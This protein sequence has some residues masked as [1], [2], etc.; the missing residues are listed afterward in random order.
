MHKLGS[1]VSRRLPALLLVA[2]VPVEPAASRERRGLQLSDL[3]ELR[4]VSD[5]RL[6]PDGKKILY[7]VESREGDRHTTS[8]IFVWDI[9]SASSAPLLGETARGVGPRW[10]PDGK[11]IAYFGA[12]GG[13]FGLMVVPASG[14]SGKLLAKVQGTNH[15]LPSSGESL[16]WSPD[17]RGIAFVSAVA[18][19]ETQ[20]AGGDPAVITRYLYKPHAGEGSTRFNDNRRL[21]IFTVSIDGS[22]LR[23]LTHGSRYEHSIDWSPS[24][25]EILF[26]SNWEPDPDRFFN[27]DIFAVKVSDGSVR[28]LTRTENIEYQPQWSPDGSSIAYLGTKRGLTSS[29]TTM[30]DTHL[31]IMDAEGN[32]RRELGATVDNRQRDHAWSPD[33]K[34]IWCTVQERGRI[35]LYRFPLSGE[36][37]SAVMPRLGGR[38][39]SWSLGKGGVIA[40]STAT[41]RDLPQLYLKSGPAEPRLLTDLNRE[42]LSSREI[43]EVESV[44]FLSFDGTEVEAFLTH[45]LGRSAGSKHP[46]IAVIKGGPHGQDGPELDYR[47]QVYAARGWASLKVNYRG[48]TG[49]GQAFAD[50]IFGDQN[51]GE[52][53]DVLYGVDAVVRRT[54][55]IDADRLGLQGGSYGGQLTMW[56]VTQTNRFRAA[57]PMYGISNLISFN[58]MAYYHDYLAVEFGT[59]PHQGDLMD[60]LWE[61][62]ALKHVAK[63]KT[64][65]LLVHGENDNDVPIAESEQFYVALK[66]VGVE[67]MMVRYPREG[68]GI[69]EIGHQIDLMERSIAWY[70]KHFLPSSGASS[71]SYASH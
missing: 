2:L 24:G 47:T 10:S 15:P 45:P 53:Q 42:L 61:R 33:G 27:Y 6:S 34:E 49:Y 23:Q 32:E 28:R 67:T 3:H 21:H 36:E 5:V 46:L 1:F 57:I 54:E 70:D 68:H 9:D 25:E 60:V 56:L 16:A 65:V 19:P 55:W 44:T 40:Y 17:S 35:G 14:G 13:E 52:A 22:G 63:V 29:E 62:S 30:E 43:A 12:D 58:Y 38:G 69:R 50:A 51:G 26:V 18:G 41:E 20:D 59:F 48:S 66:D 64:P 31:W 8:R 37:P 39:T 71:S 11:W 7:I 4:S